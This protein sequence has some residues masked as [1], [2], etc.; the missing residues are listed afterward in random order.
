MIDKQKIASA[1]FLVAVAYFMRPKKEPIMKAKRHKLQKFFVAHPVL[2]AML[3]VFGS[4]V[5]IVLVAYIT[6]EIL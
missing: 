5:V 1:V 4:V 6:Q 3:M 2:E